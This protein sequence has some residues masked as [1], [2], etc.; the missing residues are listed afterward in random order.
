MMQQQRF[1]IKYRTWTSTKRDRTRIRTRRSRKISL[2]RSK[3]SILH[4]LRRYTHLI[5]WTGQYTTLRIMIKW[6]RGTSWSKL[7]KIWRPSQVIGL[8][9]LWTTTFTISWINGSSKV[10]RSARGWLMSTLKQQKVRVNP[11]NKFLPIMRKWKRTWKLW[12]SSSKS[13]LLK[14][15][16]TWKRNSRATWMQ[17]RCRLP[18]KKSSVHSLAL[19]KLWWITRETS[20]KKSETWGTWPSSS[21]FWSR[22]KIVS[23]IQGKGYLSRTWIS[24]TILMMLSSLWIP[25]RMRSIQQ[26][27]NWFTFR[28]TCQDLRMNWESR[29]TKTITQ[30]NTQRNSWQDLNL[31]INSYMTWLWPTNGVPTRSKWLSKSHPLR[32]K[33]E[34]IKTSSNTRSRYLMCTAIHLLRKN[35][36]MAPNS[37]TL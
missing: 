20:S 28:T 24:R 31:N 23:T 17:W 15:P 2:H 22:P 21:G 37:L 16:T 36:I 8:A 11:S 3:S 26:L 13:S 7:S 29:T 5:P 30:R 33:L 19:A 6:L 12:P 10:S 14:M 32:W 34:W 1:R 27:V 4:S 18:P 25:H 35:W 9:H